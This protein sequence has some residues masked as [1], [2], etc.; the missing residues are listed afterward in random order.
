MIRSEIE[1]LSRIV[2]YQ[3][4]DMV[5]HSLV[6]KQERVSSDEF[7]RYIGSAYRHCISQAIVVP[8]TS[9]GT[10]DDYIVFALFLFG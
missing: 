4:A 5:Y 7:A 2:E 6:E 9:P 1:R 3:H 10:Q 8:T